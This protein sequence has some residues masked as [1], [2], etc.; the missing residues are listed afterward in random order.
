MTGYSAIECKIKDVICY[1]CGEFGHIST[2]CQ[3]PKKVQSGGK[4]FDLSGEWSS[5]PDGQT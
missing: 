1:R 2:K 4:L 3:K 5:E